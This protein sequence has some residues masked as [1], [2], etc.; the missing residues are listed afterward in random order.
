MW[1]PR[2]RSLD[3]TRKLVPLGMTVGELQARYGRDRD[4]QSGQSLAT[5]SVCRLTATACPG[6]IVAPME[7]GYAHLLP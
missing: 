6:I 5:C 3:F 7:D 1:Y 4:R 2:P